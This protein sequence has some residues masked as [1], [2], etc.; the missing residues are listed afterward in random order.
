MMKTRSK[1]FY[2][3]IAVVVVD[4]LVVIWGVA[5][6]NGLVTSSTLVEQSQHDIDSQLQRRSDLIPNLVATVKGYAAHETDAIKAVTDARAQMAGAQ[7]NPDKAA[8]DTNLTS[9]LNRLLVVVENYPNL[10]AD[11]NFRALQDELAGTEN[12][13]NF[14]RQSYNAVVQS[15]N[16][17]IRSFPTNIIASMGSFKQATYFEASKG[18]QQ[19]PTV[20]FGS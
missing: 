14:A 13:I 8:A 18:A 4:V 12:R 11:A 6:Y 20:S 9:A 1:G 19:V 5:T 17:K 10:K 15:Y 2:A 7:T 16:A 3:I